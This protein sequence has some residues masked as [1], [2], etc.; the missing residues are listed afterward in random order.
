M[1][2]P[3]QILAKFYDLEKVNKDD[4]IRAIDLLSSLINTL[5]E[6]IKQ[7]TENVERLLEEVIYLKTTFTKD[8]EEIATRD[9][10]ELIYEDK[11][12]FLNK[13]PERF[14][15]EEESSEWFDNLYEGSL[16]PSTG[17]DTEIFLTLKDG[18]VSE[19]DRKLL[20]EATHADQR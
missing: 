3:Q 8:S 10:Y 14:L 11:E 5:D 15:T 1:I 12:V 6:K 4:L 16:D 19:N 18:Y 13:L 20:K 17:Y 7:K 2:I 9:T